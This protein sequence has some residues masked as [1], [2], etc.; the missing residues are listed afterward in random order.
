[1]TVP[2]PLLYQ[3]K[4]KRMT[5]G[6]ISTRWSKCSMCNMVLMDAEFLAEQTPREHLAHARTHHPFT[7]GG[8][9]TLKQY[10]VR[11]DGF[12]HRYQTRYPIGSFYVRVCV[13]SDDQ[14]WS[15]QVLPELAGSMT[16]YT[17]ERR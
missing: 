4:W 2:A 13:G 15:E 8:I 1:M 11:V 16:D 6:R 14:P 12:R 9:Q 7:Y 3:I 10:L 17:W 5:A